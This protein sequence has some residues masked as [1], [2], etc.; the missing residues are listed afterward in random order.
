LTAFG[1][2]DIGE[3]GIGE[4]ETSESSRLSR[5]GRSLNRDGESMGDDCSG[6]ADL[7]CDLCFIFEGLITLSCVM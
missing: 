3:D 5:M 1:L 4:E 2:G 6:L 7:F